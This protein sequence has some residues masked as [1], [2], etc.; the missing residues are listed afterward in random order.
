[1]IQKGQK[2]STDFPK[3]T[4]KWNKK[5]PIAPKQNKEHM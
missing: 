5:T 4:D 2:V 1:M 3:H